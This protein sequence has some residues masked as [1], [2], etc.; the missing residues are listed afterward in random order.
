[1]KNAQSIKLHISTSVSHHEG[2]LSSESDKSDMT[3]RSELSSPFGFF[4][5]C[6]LGRGFCTL[7]KKCLVFVTDDRMVKES[8]SGEPFCTPENKKLLCLDRPSV[9]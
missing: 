2:F 1:M 3:T 6:I 8:L 7:R 9:W 4:N 5:F